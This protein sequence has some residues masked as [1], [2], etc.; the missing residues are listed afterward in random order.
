MSGALVVVEWSTTILF[1]FC[2]FLRQNLLLVGLWYGEKK[3][4]MTSFLAPLTKELNRLSEHG[5][6]YDKYTN[7]IQQIISIFQGLELIHQTVQ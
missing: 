2:R 6:F 7:Y 5:M 3:P 4:T 1:Y